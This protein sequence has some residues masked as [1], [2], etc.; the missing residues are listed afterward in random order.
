MSVKKEFTL[1]VIA[2]WTGTLILY[3]L[4]LLITP[5]IVHSLGDDKYGIWSLAISLTGYYGIID[6]GINSTAIKLFS[7][8]NTRGDIKECN[9]I[10]NTV[11]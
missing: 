11:C 7:D 4:A 3:T 5:I 10:V 1:S 9:K 6:F 8:S 2:N